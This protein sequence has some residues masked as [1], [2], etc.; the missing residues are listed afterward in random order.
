MKELIC[1]VLCAVCNHQVHPIMTRVGTTCTVH[2]KN[3]ARQD[4]SVYWWSIFRHF[5]PMTKTDYSY[6]EQKI[7]IFQLTKDPDL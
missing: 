3:L 7:Q 5:F 4:H 2:V 1:R 6:T